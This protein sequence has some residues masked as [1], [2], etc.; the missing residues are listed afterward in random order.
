MTRLAADHEAS[1]INAESQLLAQPTPRP[2]YC[3]V[4]EQSNHLIE[5]ASSE[6][7]D[8]LAINGVYLSL[9]YTEYDF[10]CTNVNCTWRLGV[11]QNTL[12]KSCSSCWQKNSG[13][14]NG[15]NRTMHFIIL[16]YP[17]TV[18]TLR[19]KESIMYHVYCTF[20]S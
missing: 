7:H 9:S 15:T 5:D 8:H 13:Q 14:S 16:S 11:D 1:C 10:T 17:S 18:L 4:M 12:T 2:F 20:V 19:D 6:H 3:Q